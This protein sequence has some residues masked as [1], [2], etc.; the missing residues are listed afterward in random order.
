MAKDYQPPRMLTWAVYALGAAG[1]GALVVG[2]VLE[3]GVLFLGGVGA[4]VGALIGHNTLDALA[5]RQSFEPG[6][7]QGPWG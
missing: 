1:V 6:D 4:T 7:R 3:V 2:V 5:R